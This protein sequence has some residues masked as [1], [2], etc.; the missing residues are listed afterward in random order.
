MPRT[1]CGA[2]GRSGRPCKGIA[3]ANGRCRFHGGKSTG[4]PKGNTNTVT[5]GFYSSALLPEE[6]VLYE[7]VQVGGLDDELRLARVK[8]YRF[9]QRSGSAS[10]QSLVDGALEVIQRSGEEMDRGV[11]QP[12]DRRELKAAAP[13]YGD[14]IIR[15]LDV[16]RKLELARQQLNEGKEESLQ[17]LE[18]DYTLSPDGDVP[19]KPVL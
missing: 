9:V 3:M 13:D 15:Q 19:A 6:R 8:L 12:Y 1:E 7:R 14:L 18:P 4:P 2:K 11:S 5:H 10:L 16:I 17:D